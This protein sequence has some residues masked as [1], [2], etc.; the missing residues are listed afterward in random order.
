MLAVIA[1]LGFWAFQHWSKIEPAP[2]ATPRVEHQPAA[3]AVPHADDQQI[4]QPV[5]DSVIR[6]V[7]RA[8]SVLRKTKS[9]SGKR[10]KK[11]SKGATLTVLQIDGDW[12][13]VRDGP[14]TGW[15][16]SSVLGTAPPK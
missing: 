8:G 2:K 11:E 4:A 14:L 13:K 6:Y 10:L 12:T 15:M 9:K 3:K 16:R 5:A 7:H 1:G